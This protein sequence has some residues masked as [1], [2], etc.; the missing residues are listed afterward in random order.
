MRSVFQATV[1]I[2]NWVWN[3]FGLDLVR[4][5]AIAVIITCFRTPVMRP[6]SFTWWRPFKV[7]TIVI[8]ALTK[9]ENKT[10]SWSSEFFEEKTYRQTELSLYGVHWLLIGVSLS[11]FW[12]LFTSHADVLKVCHYMRGK[13][14]LKMNLFAAGVYPKVCSALSNSDLACSLVV[15]AL[16]PFSIHPTIFPTWCSITSPTTF[17]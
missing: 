15:N 2:V 13:N 7:T 1:G 4:L 6:I 14:T 8:T 11:K 17:Y 12:A 16:F 5:I 10:S 3:W 9:I